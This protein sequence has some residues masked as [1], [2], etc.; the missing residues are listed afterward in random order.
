MFP[1]L[2]SEFIK[3]ENEYRHSRSH[4]SFRERS[5]VRSARAGRDGAAARTRRAQ[6]PTVAG[7][8]WSPRSV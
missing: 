6:G 3:A 5:I 2:T 4:R 1:A 7:A 8:T